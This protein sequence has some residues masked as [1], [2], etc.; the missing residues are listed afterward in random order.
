MNINY[1]LYFKYM[2]KY[3]KN[4]RIWL[5]IGN[6]ANAGFGFLTIGIL[7]RTLD[8]DDFGAWI[9][10]LTNMGL[11]EMVRAGLVYQALVK[12][13][14]GSAEKT[15]KEIVINAAWQISFLLSLALILILL[16]SNYLFSELIKANHLDLFFKFYPIILLFMLPI[17][18]SVWVAH[19]QQKYLKMW[20]V[21]FLSSF[22]F[23]IFILLFK[24]PTISQ[25]IM[26]FGGIRALLAIVSSFDL[27]LKI[28]KI[29][30]VNT[31]KKIFRFSKYTVVTTLSTNVLKSA[32]LL[33]INAYLGPVMVAMYNIPLKLLEV[34]EIPLRSWTMSAYP[35][36]SQLASQHDFISFKKKFTREVKFFSFFLLPF[37]GIAFH[38]SEQIITLYAGQSFS[39]A[40]NI[41]KIFTIYLLL[42]PLDRYLGIALD[43]LDLPQINALK[44]V[45]MASL[46]VF[47]DWY[48]LSHQIGLHGIAIVTIINVVSG[49]LVG[50]FFLNQ[51]LTS[52]NSK[53]SI[54][55]QI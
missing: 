22:P 49:I 27:R 9:I 37:L 24:N 11:V 50:L 44:V 7:A 5:M 15:E 34:I 54:V 19:A 2:T 18:M 16:I 38:F 46:N 1:L 13:V 40:S 31:A 39:K 36:L 21:N 26:A 51:K 20:L 3:L 45:L 17:N 43:S 30:D 42:M 4:A 23:L 53:V 32:D 10:F 14:S 48:I 12:F 41:L 33:L 47:G 28:F 29:L 25:I 52:V 8:A 35:K 6:I 55:S